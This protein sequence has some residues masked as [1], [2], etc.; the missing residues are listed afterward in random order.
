MFWII[1]GDVFF[2]A[3]L[4]F[5]DAPWAE[6]LETQLHHSQW[7]GFT[8]YDLIFPLFLFIV[9]LSMPFAISKRLQRGDS[10]KDLYTHIIKR[11]LILFALGLVYN[12]I[13]DLNF[14]SFRWAG[15]LQ[16]IALCYFFAAMIFMNF[17]IKGQAIAIGSIVFGYWAMMT[18][19]P[20]PGFGAGVLTPE[21]NL[22]SFIDRLLLPGRSCC[23][24]F[25]DNEGILTTIPA[26]A[27]TLLGG[28]A[29]HLLRSPLGQQKKLS[30]L[31]AAGFSS[32]I[33]ALLWSLFFPINKLL[34]SSSYVLFAAGWSFL[35]VALFYWVIDLRGHKKWAFPFVVVGLNP[36]TIY[37]LHGVFDFGSIAGIFVNGFIVYLGDIRPVAWIACV[38]LVKWLFL[39]FLYRQKI[40]LKA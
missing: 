38:L 29:G 9:G 19:I 20:V 26:I 18:L 35:L 22:A 8:F 1:G 28:L 21:G 3:F 31:V 39:Y 15:V 2:R 27:T 11:T 7:N 37:V 36:I 32:L 33:L 13:L 5:S 4:K 12:H 25:G 30:G 17:R 34:W 40:F 16:R 24:K 6:A 10:R 23:F 14:S